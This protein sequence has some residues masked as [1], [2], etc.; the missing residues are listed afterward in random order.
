MVFQIDNDDNND[1]YYEPEEKL[2]P[3]MGAVNMNNYQSIFK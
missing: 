3:H 1:A 2:E